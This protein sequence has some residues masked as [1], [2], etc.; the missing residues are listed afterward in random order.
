MLNWVW[1]GL[2][3]GGLVYAGF[4]GQMQAVTDEI[5][6]SA[7]GAV[8]L[9]FGLVGIMVFLLG[10]LRVAR[11]GGLLRWVAQLIAPLLDSPRPATR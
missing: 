8:D 10:L 9:V 7:R 1:L 6:A 3:L 5:Y 2:I 11:D 4:T